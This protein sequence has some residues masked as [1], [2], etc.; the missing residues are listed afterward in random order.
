MER[1]RQQNDSLADGYHQV[2]WAVDDETGKVIYSR[3]LLCSTMM[4]M[5]NVYLIRV[6][7]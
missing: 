3:C 4:M 5:I 7:H 1:G 6:G 2:E